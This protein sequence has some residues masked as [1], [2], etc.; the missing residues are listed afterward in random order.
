MMELEGSNFSSITRK[1]QIYW[2]ESAINFFYG[3]LCSNHLIQNY[4]RIN[5]TLDADDDKMDTIKV[6]FSWIPEILDWEI[7]DTRLS[8]RYYEFKSKSD[9][10]T[11]DKSAKIRI[12]AENF[13]TTKILPDKVYHHSLNPC[14]SSR[15]F[16]L[17]S[18]RHGWLHTRF[19]WVKIL[20]AYIFISWC[21]CEIICTYY[22]KLIMQ[23]CNLK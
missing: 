22:A 14:Q 2:F 5:P 19:F 16:S 15:V 17:Y 8:M 7:A 1:L 10:I 13:L 23:N 3:F 4:S 11:A 6:L 9:K 12:A 21:I 18:I 20:T